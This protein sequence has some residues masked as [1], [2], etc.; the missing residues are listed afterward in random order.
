[1]TRAQLM[2]E[3]ATKGYRTEPINTVKNGVTHEGIRFIDDGAVQPVIYTDDIISVEQA[4]SLYEQVKE[5]AVSINVSKVTGK[6]YM[7][8][9]IRIGLQRES[10]QTD[11]VKRPTKFNRI[12]QYLYVAIDDNSS[13]KVTQGMI[14]DEEKLWER[15]LKN[16]CADIMFSSF[17]GTMDFLTNQSKYRGAASVLNEA[18]LERFITE[19][20]WGTKAILLPSSIHEWI[21]QPYEDGTDIAAMSQMVRDI[22]ASQVAPEE[23]LGDCA[24]LVEFV[25]GVMTVRE[26]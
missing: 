14:G 3:L 11:I 23:Q 12:E 16:T 21:L 15:A 2:N 18:E 6:E 8:E 25:D 20:G 1:M 19:K 17:W 10:Y 22:N 7:L 24:Y 4:V 26:G 9:H 13:Y 5:Q